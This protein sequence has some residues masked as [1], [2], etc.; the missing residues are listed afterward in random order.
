MACPDGCLHGGAQVRSQKRSANKIRF[1]NV[2]ELY[3]SHLSIYG[4][5][6]ESKRRKL[7]VFYNQLI[8][9]SPYSSTAR[10]LFHEQREVI[11]REV[12]TD[13]PTLSW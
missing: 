2:Q 5:I 11:N 4:C 9:S 1:R 8:Q 6:E 10:T 3:Q 13:A 7:D 12:N